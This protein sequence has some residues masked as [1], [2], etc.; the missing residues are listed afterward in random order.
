MCE[1]CEKQKILKSCNFCGGAK[2]LIHQKGF[3]SDIGMLELYGE[4][5][6]FPHIQNNIQT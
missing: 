2:L 6:R 4:E 3:K 1:F 5:S